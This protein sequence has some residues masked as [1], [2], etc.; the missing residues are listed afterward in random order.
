MHANKI[1]HR[2]LKPENVL[3]TLDG[4]VKLADFGLAKFLQPNQSTKSFCGT[5]EYLAPEVLDMKGHGFA[6]D[7]WTLGILI[8][9]MITGRPPFMNANH[10]RLGV[11]I[12]QGVIIFPDPVRHGIPMSE[13]L[14]DLITKLLDKDPKTRIGSKNDADEIV[15]HPWFKGFDW[16]GLMARRIPAPFIPDVEKIRKRS[17]VG[18]LPRPEPEK[19]R[20]DAADNLPNGLVKT[21]V[22]SHDEKMKPKSKSQMEEEAKKL[23]EGVAD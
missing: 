7:W 5:A 4:Y 13:E 19:N 3:M 1:V 10:H 6:V 22:L 11:L 2:D 23:A 21:G 8:Y 9:E 15:N 16:D 20:K 14:K 12:R 17:S 18:D